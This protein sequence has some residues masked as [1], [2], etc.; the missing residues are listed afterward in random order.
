MWSMCS[1]DTGVKCANVRANAS[2]SSVKNMSE[3]VLFVLF[4]SSVAPVS[5]DGAHAG[6]DQKMLEDGYQCWD[7]GKYVPYFLE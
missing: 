1:S 5:A 7:K 3:K 4:G 2:N 6:A